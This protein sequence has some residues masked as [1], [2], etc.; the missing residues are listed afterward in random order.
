MRKIFYTV[1]GLTIILSI[2]LTFA[3]VD[4]TDVKGASSVLIHSGYTPISVGGYDFWNG[5]KNDFYKTKFTAKA[6]NGDI[7]TGCVTKGLFGKGST[8]RLND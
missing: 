5:G 8:I 7:V 3:I 6:P 2:I 1:F 4:K